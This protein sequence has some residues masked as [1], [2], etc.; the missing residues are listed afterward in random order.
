MMGNNYLNTIFPFKENT[1]EQQRQVIAVSIVSIFTFF[2]FIIIAVS[3]LPEYCF[4][5]S[6]NIE[7]GF[8]C[9]GMRPDNSPCPICED[10]RTAKMATI[11]AVLGICMLIIPFIIFE[12]KKYRNSSIEQPKLFD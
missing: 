3:I 7:S 8:A 2:V 4:L 6:S 11:I 10:K 1:T 12:L 5:F 9:D